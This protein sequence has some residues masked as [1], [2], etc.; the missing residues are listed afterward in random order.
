MK[1]EKQSVG[2]KWGR[3]E[4]QEM[5]WGR[6]EKRRKRQRKNERGKKNKWRKWNEIQKNVFY[7]TILFVH[8]LVF[9]IIYHIY[10]PLRSGRISEFSFSSTS[11]LT[12]AE[13]TSLS[14]YLPIAGGRIIGFIPFPRLLVLCEMQSVSPGFELMSPCPFHTMITITPRAPPQII[15]TS[16]FF[17]W[18]SNILKSIKKK[19]KSLIL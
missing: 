10:Q 11:C 19:Q 4:K 5:K 1:E 13:E 7:Q 16:L 17:H 9:Q 15:Y 3:G 12:K 14:Y 18:K 6:K 8:L 2:N